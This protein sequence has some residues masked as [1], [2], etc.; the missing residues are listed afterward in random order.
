MDAA[1]PHPLAEVLFQAI[2]PRTSLYIWHNVSGTLYCRNNQGF[3]TATLTG[4]RFPSHRLWHN[5][6][7]IADIPQNEFSALWDADPNLRRGA[8]MAVDTVNATAVLLSQED[9]IQEFR[10][11]DDGWGVP[12][13]RQQGAAGA[14]IEGL[15][16]GMMKQQ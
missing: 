8:Q 2:V 1:R 5:G 12:D 7:K 10:L 16:K 9:N 3:Y 4:S 14:G 11:Y 15:L 13:L 6:A